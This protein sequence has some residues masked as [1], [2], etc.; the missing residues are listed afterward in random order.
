MSRANEF[1]ATLRQR[2]GVSL[3][4]FVD[5]RRLSFANEDDDAVV[6]IELRTTRPTSDTLVLRCVGVSGFRLSDFGGGVTQVGELAVETISKNQ[7][8]GLRWEVR[9]FEKDRLHLYCRDVE[10]RASLLSGS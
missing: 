7:L 1:S 10:I 9:D 6:E 2:G 8:Q 5:V 4:G 3:T